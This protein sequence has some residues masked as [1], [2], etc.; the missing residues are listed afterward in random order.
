[1][2]GNSYNPPF[3]DDSFSSGSV[4][5]GAMLAR[6]FSPDDETSSEIEAD[7]MIPSVLLLTEEN[8]MYV[9]EN[10]AFVHIVAPLDGETLMPVRM[11]YGE[12]N[13]QKIFYR[14]EDGIYMSNRLIKLE[15][16][17]RL[18]SSI[19]DNLLSLRR[20]GIMHKSCDDGS[21]AVTIELDER[22]VDD[23][24]AAEFYGSKFSFSELG[25]ESREA[26]IIANA[27][28][29]WLKLIK[30]MIPCCAE[31]E[32]MITEMLP[33]LEQVQNEFMEMRAEGSLAT[34]HSQVAKALEWAMTCVEITDLIFDTRQSTFC[35]FLGASSGLGPD[36]HQTQEE[37]HR[38]Q[39]KQRL[40][41]YIDQLAIYEDDFSDV[42]VAA[43]V[44]ELL[45]DIETMEIAS[46]NFII[47]FGE[48]TRQQ[49]GMLRLCTYVDQHPELNEVPRPLQQLSESFRR[50]SVDFV[51]CAKFMFWPSVASEWKTRNR[52]WPEQLV[53]DQIVSKG[54]HLVGKA[55]C[56]DY[57]DW[58]LSFSV[59]EIE[60]ATRWSAVQHFVY[61]I[62][63]SLFYKFIKPLYEDSAAAEAE[64]SHKPS[65]KT[66]LASYMAKTVMMWTSESVDQS[67]WTEDNAAECVTLLLLVLQSAFE[68]RTLHHYFV[69]SVNLLNGLPDELAS[70]VVNTINSILADPAAV[71]EQ[72]DKHFEKTEI[73]FNA[74]PAQVECEKKMADFSQLMSSCFA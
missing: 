49:I 68:C 39:V 19:L 35:R 24:I 13:A 55:F 32:I 26:Q 2:H 18:S 37:R 34:L 73:V 8:L 14:K 31:F 5:E 6:L 62:F 63:K 11:L 25:F 10:K 53:I 30:E 67:W 46:R 66:Y 72:L 44:R 16:K 64:V 69:S 57:L 15:Y 4:V 1:M 9:D 20:P 51:P 43:A 47:A 61:F 54:G 12:D 48:F 28:D 38:E 27:T 71:V 33:H 52:L 36:C 41:I 3:D 23:K 50:L 74:M 65:S 40:Q 22:N 17:E 21:A 42:S 45:S 29:V 56:H 70:R 60:L 58:R 59:A 7:I